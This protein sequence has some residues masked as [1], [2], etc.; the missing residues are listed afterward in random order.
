MGSGNEL[1]ARLYSDG[2]VSYYSPL[3]VI[4]FSFYY[5]LT[6]LSYTIYQP[7]EV[8]RCNRIPSLLYNSSKLIICTLPTCRLIRMVFLSLVFHL[9]PHR[10]N[11]IDIW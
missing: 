9:I 7:I 3:C 2:T 11:R 6:P 10:L 8:F 1:S 4:A 5:V